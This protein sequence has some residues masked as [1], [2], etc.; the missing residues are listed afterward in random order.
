MIWIDNNKGVLVLLDQV[1]AVCLW[2]YCVQ[3]CADPLHCG[4]VITSMPGPWLSKGITH[5]LVLLCTYMI[6]Y[7]RWKL[8]HVFSANKETVS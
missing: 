3:S 1:Q 4:W 6:V 2:F 8:S 7:D 5:T